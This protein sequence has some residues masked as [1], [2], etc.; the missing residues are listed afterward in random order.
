MGQ[1]KWDTLVTV[2]MVY[3]DNQVGVLISYHAP[4]RKIEEAELALHTA[5]ANQ[6]A[7]A[8]QNALLLTEVQG[9]AALEERQKLA[10]ELHD[11]V[12]QAIFSISL[13]ART[14]QTLVRTDPSRVEEPLGHIASLS[15]AAMAEMRAL[16]FELRPESLQ[17]EGLVA[18]IAKQVSALH[19]RHNIEVQ[20]ELCEEPALTLEQKQGVYRIAQEALHNTVKHARA[21]QVTIKVEC[22]EEWLTLEVK[23]NGIGFAPAG[24]FPGHL[25]LQ[26]MRE[27]AAK[28]GGTLQIESAPGEG[29]CIRLRLRV[30]STNWA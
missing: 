20:T 22:D 12:S 13:Q 11:S 9:K 26:S 1:V 7:V 3:G 19:A 28:L 27:R 2:P 8:V 18:A 4:T 15:Q 17:N 25:G 14:A 5:I 23:D 29:T 30:A 16:I 24:K 21:S 10:R 6:A